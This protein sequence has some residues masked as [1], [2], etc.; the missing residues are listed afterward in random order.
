MAAVPI[1]DGPVGAGDC[2]GVATMPCLL[3]PLP[4][5]SPPTFTFPLPLTAVPPCIGALFTTIDEEREWAADAVV[6]VTIVVV[7][8]VTGAAGGI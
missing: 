6:V 8:V 7:V 4:S 3:L 5:Q 2:D 1:D